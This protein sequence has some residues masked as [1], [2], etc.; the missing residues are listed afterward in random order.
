MKLLN[1][2]KTDL[3]W[4]M[5]S[6]TLKGGSVFHKQTMIGEI[7]SAIKKIDN[8]LL[9][10]KAFIVSIEDVAKAVNYRMTMKQLRNA[11]K[12][13]KNPSDNLA[14]IGSEHIDES[15]DGEFYIWCDMCCTI[16]E[17]SKESK[18]YSSIKLNRCMC[19]DCTEFGLKEEKK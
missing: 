13:V 17:Q 11:L 16:S 1:E 14:R 9:D 7:E 8:F 5:Q 2:L 19:D 15:S 4:S 10:E 3:E 12:D 6:Y 18:E